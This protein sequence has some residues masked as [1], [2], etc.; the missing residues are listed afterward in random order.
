MT[1][2]YAARSGHGYDLIVPDLS[3]VDGFDP[4]GSLV[5]GRTVAWT[6]LRSGGNAPLGGEAAPTD[7]T[8]R[9]AA[10]GSGTIAAP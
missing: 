10:Q 8:Y 5:S 3:T 4:A 7:G 2:T 6:A 1:G 9:I